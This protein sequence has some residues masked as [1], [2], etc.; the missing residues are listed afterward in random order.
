ME[1][2]CKEAQL[3]VA[4]FRLSSWTWQFTDGIG[5]P[6]AFSELVPAEKRRGYAFRQFAAQRTSEAGRSTRTEPIPGSRPLAGPRNWSSI[7]PS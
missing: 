2:S 7:S 3:A 1:G 4:D 5:F 6:D